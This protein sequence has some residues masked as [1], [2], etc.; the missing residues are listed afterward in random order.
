MS[1]AR[2]KSMEGTVVGERYQAIKCLRKS[3]V[4]KTY[5]CRDMNEAQKR[6]I[7]KIIH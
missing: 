2:I 1:A 7:L 3:N 6:L 4:K 5:S